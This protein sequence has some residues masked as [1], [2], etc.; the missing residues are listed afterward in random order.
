MK[1]SLAT[2]AI[3]ALLATGAT[4][5]QALSY[6]GTK[7]GSSIFTSGS[8]LSIKDNKNDGQFPSVNYKYAGGTKQGG[9]A[10][11]NG[12]GVTLSFNAPSSIT[13][14]Q[15]CISRTALPMSCGSWIY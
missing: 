8:Y 6:T 15:P 5:A 1:K 2:I 14:I 11:K 13:A 9:I 4:S 12:Y 10:N 3:V 7:Y